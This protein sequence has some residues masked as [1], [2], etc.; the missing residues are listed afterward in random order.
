VPAE[1][2]DSSDPTDPPAA[3]A[4]PP[5][6][7]LLRLPFYYGWVVVSVAFVTMG[8]GVS[9]RTSFSLLFPPILDE[10]GWQRGATAGIFSVGFLCSA[11][12]S[13]FIGAAVDRFGPRRVIPF[14]ALVVAAGLLL[15]TVAATPWQ[16]Y[17][18]LGVLVTGGTVMFSYIGHSMFLPHW[19][20]RRRGLAMGL[21]FS[22]VGV[23][24]IVLFPLLQTVIG[25]AGWREACWLM[26]GLLVAVVL[27]LNFLLQRKRPEDLGLLPDGAHRSGGAAQRSALQAAVVDRA[28][29]Q[30]DWTLRRAM[31]TGRF[32]WLS[33]A[34]F[35]GLYAWY[36]VQVHQTKYLIDVG[37]GAEAA[38]VALG[39][40][41]LGGIAGQIGLGHLSDRVG[42]EWAWSIAAGG[43]GACYVLLLLIGHYPHPALVYGMVAVQGL[44]GYGAASVYGVMP[45]ELFQGR[46]YGRVFGVISL[47][48][49]VGAAAGPWATG[50]LQDRFGSYAQAFWLGIA[51][52]LVSIGA[53]WLAAPRKV[54]L[55]AGRVGRVRSG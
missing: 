32:W 45:A 15:T 29:A 46:H 39:L 20:Y 4:S 37:V 33:L 44:L 21:A 23:G 18:T 12:Y 1:P 14:G 19:F 41:G 30:T 50:E 36:A 2:S 5:A 28:W 11:L 7:P 40:V 35:C 38:A 9:V 3:G 10:F 34:Y 52:S 51:V 27:P 22:G 54:R 43:F 55:V 26:A 13:P 25:T 49:S 16:M 24:A 8:I 53:V 42:R 48:A 31:G 17:L 47:S 6:N